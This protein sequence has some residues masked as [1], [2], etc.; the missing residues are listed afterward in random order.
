MTMTL[1]LHVY[2]FILPQRTI[3]STTRRLRQ[4]Q[5]QQSTTPLCKRF[6]DSSIGLP[7]RQL[8]AA[9]C[10]VQRVASAPFARRACHDDKPTSRGP[11]PPPPPPPLRGK[12]DNIHY[13]NCGPKHAG[14]DTGTRNGMATSGQKACH[15]SI[16]VGDES[17]GTTTTT[18]SSFAA[19]RRFHETCIIFGQD[20]RRM[21]HGSLSLVVGNIF[22]AFW[23]TRQRCLSRRLDQKTGLYAVD[24]HA[25][26]RTCQR[27][28]DRVCTWRL[29]PFLPDKESCFA[30]QA[31]ARPTRW[32][33][34]FS[35]RTSC[36]EARVKD[37]AKQQRT[38]CQSDNVRNKH[39]PRQG[40][41][42]GIRDTNKFDRN[43]KRNED[44][45]SNTIID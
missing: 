32:S 31:R 37:G 6:H 40:A 44:P 19:P 22:Q 17:D 4:E 2:E 8:A 33:G 43:N 3:T 27:I 20:D 41:R 38:Q 12:Q 5:Q 28:G 16:P 18:T 21:P 7:F 11:Q 25:W 36:R 39:P 10:V 34:F 29:Q 42:N 13:A 30:R 23:T 24:G 15:E 14:G 45:L 1:A 35:G 9:V 26:P